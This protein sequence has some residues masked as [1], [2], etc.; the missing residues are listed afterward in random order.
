M[1]SFAT[2]LSFALIIASLSA[3]EDTKLPKPD[4]DGWMTL[5]NG[6]DLAGWDGDPKVCRV[7]DGYISGAI[8]KLE[9]GNTFLVFKKPFSNFVLEADC[10]LV[11]RKGQQRDSVSFQAIRAR[12]QQ[13]G[14]ERLSS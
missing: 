4:A 9:G 11:G 7:K 1:K 2:I 14:G 8:E 3:Q 13:V 10:V 5:F 12:R 6:K